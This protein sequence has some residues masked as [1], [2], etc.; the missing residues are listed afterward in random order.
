MNIYYYIVC[1]VH[2]YDP[3]SRG[4]SPLFLH[5]QARPPIY[6][7][8]GLALGL[9]STK[10]HMGISIYGGIPGWGTVTSVLIS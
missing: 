5:A 4:G 6:R 9:G 8:E 1:K 3:T 2:P 10:L 7:R